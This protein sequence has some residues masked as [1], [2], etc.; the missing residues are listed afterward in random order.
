MIQGRFDIN[1]YTT[2][3]GRVEACRNDNDE[4][5]NYAMIELIIVV[6]YTLESKMGRV[7]CLAEILGMTHYK[8]FSEN[9]IFMINIPTNERHFQ[10]VAFVDWILSFE[11]QEFFYRND[12]LVLFDI[13]VRQLQ[14][15]DDQAVLKLTIL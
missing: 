14:R 9:L 1:F 15:T 8:T 6:S 4:D 5:Y 2:I 7:C 11:L 10:I 3:L 12:A 13:I